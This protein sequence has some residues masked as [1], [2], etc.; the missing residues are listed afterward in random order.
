MVSDNDDPEDDDT[1][2]ARAFFA[3]PATRS[4]YVRVYQ[5]RSKF[6]PRGRID[7]GVLWRDLP[8]DGR[9]VVPMDH[10][11][12]VAAGSGTDE[13]VKWVGEQV[14][15]VMSRLEWNREHE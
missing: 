4:G 13:M 2:R 8:A 11:A 9:Y 12:P 5:G 14:A 3:T 1:Y 7:M 10:P 6:G 15:F